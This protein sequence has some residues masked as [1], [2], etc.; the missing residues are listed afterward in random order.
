MNE[1]DPTMT[2]EDWKAMYLILF[3]GVRDAIAQMPML[4]ENAA[5]CERLVRASQD[6]EEY[7]IRH[8]EP[9]DGQPEI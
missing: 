4:P 7:Y 6:A 8:G 2:A 9:V 1:I 5:A 3:H